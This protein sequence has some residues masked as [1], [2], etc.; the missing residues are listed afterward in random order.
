M[1]LLR[2]I[3]RLNAADPSAAHRFVVDGQTMGLIHDAFAAHL[4]F[5]TKVFAIDDRQVRFV[6]GLNSSEART[7]ALAE[8]GHDLARRGLIGRLRGEI[9]PAKNAF[10]DPA[11]FYLDRTL[12]SYLGLRAYGV[13]VN[14]FVATP[15]GPWLWLARRA[16]DR[17][18]EPDKLDNMVAGGQPAHLSLRDNLI[19]E[20]AEEADVPESLARAARPVSTVTYHME[21]T[22]GHKP[23]C[24]FCYDLEVPENF[25]PRPQDGE[26]ASFALVPARQ[27]LE[28]VRTTD[29]FK[30]NVT[31][32]VIDFALRHG[33]IDPDVDPSFEALA[34]GLRAGDQPFT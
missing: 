1:G 34:A 6:S 30:F 27:A 28:M 9:Y 4:A 15:D 24:M 22:T 16:P 7:G 21:T 13:H 29:A 18:V 26:V 32:V 12:V 2:H 19:K 3:H 33:L 31:L 14:G 5:Y 10:H 20:C 25:I 11:A 8:V 23:D 17:L